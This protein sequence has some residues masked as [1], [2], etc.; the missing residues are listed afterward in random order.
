MAKKMMKRSLALG[1]LMAFAITGSAMAADYTMSGDK[2]HNVSEMITGENT[3]SGSGTLTINN[4]IAQNHVIM[5]SKLTVNGVDLVINSAVTG[6]SDWGVLRNATINSDSKITIN[7]TGKD[8]A[9]GYMAANDN[10]TAAELNIV[11]KGAS[12]IYSNGDDVKVLDADKITLES[13]FVDGTS[14]AGT[15]LAENA[16]LTIKDFNELTSNTY[17]EVTNDG[18]YGFMSTGNSTIVITGRED[19][20]VKVYSEGMAAL[21][22]INNGSTTVTASTVELSEDKFRD[23][24]EARKSGVVAVQDSG[25]L[26]INVDKKLTIEDKQNR[27]GENATNAIKVTGGNFVLNNTQEAVVEIK[28]DITQTAGSMTLELKNAES[29][30][31]GT[32]NTATEDA[33][34]SFSNG[35]TWNN[36]GASNVKKLTATNA[37][38]NQKASENITVGEFSG[39]ATVNFVEDGKLLINAGEGSIEVTTQ[40]GKADETVANQIGK[41]DAAN[42]TATIVEAE[43]AVTGENIREITFSKEDTAAAGYKL[44]TLGEIISSKANTT[45]PA[46]ADMA[47]LGLAAWRADNGTLMQRMG[48]LRNANGEQGTWARMTRT[49]SEYGVADMQ[50]NTYSVGYDQKVA[51][52]W[53]VGAAITYKDASASSTKGS[54]DIEQK[55]IAFY[56]TKLNENG[57]YIDIVAKYTNLDNDYTVNGGI[58]SGDYDADAYSLSAEYGKRFTQDNGFWVEPQAELTYGHVG[59]ASYTTAAGKA[60]QD[61]FDSFVGRVGVLVGKDVSAGNVYAKASYL[62]DFDGEAS[63]TFRDAKDKSIFQTYEDDLG[64]GWFEVGVGTNINLSKATYVYADVEKTFSGDVD[65]KWQWN[66]GVRYSF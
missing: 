16:Q 12:A 27:E 43:G 3:L 46:I 15:F 64:G 55:G 31:N 28:G 54:A 35:A 23:S 38:I 40:A 44:G 36:D 7:Q 48:E 6:E 57:S 29:S 58:G 33:K 63:M 25:Q 62:Y 47:A 13:T 51:N 50:G 5:D 37:V 2:I 20:T 53:T 30:L 10:I 18:G 49:E 24:D 52:D 19:S 66:L 32:I 65:T 1:A 39:T 45:N 26:T 8:A 22:A 60:A 17:T 14:T 59:S 41:M 42:I 21:G 4:G 56:G 34:I 9:I 11:S 61:S